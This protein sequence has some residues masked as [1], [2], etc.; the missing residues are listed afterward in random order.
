MKEQVEINSVI[1]KIMNERSIAGGG[2]VR[3][4]SGLISEFFPVAAMHL[5]NMVC[6]RAPGLR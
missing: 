1:V 5:A 3:K 2:L 6:M 4:A